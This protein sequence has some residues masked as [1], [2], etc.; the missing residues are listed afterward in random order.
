MRTKMLLLL[1]AV[2][3]GAF[4]ENLSLVVKNSQTPQLNLKNKT[5]LTAPA[6]GLW[7][8]ATKWENQWPSGWKHAS[9]TKEEQVGDWQVLTGELALKKGRFLIRDAY[10][11]EGNRVK[12]IRRFRWKGKQP[13]D[14][15]TLS[16]RWQFK[17]ELPQVFI[18][19]IIYYGNPSGEKNGAHKLPVY[20][21][22]NG[23]KAIFEEHRFPLP[24]A[25]F[26]WK[27]GNK[28]MGAALHTKPSPVYGGKHFDQWWSL[29][30]ESFEDYSELVMLSG[31]ITYNGKPSV[32]KALQHRAMK[33][34][35]TWMKFEPGD[36]VEKTFYL[37]AYDVKEQGSGFQ[38]PMYTSIDIFKPFYTEDFPTFQEIITDKYRFTKSRYMETDDYAGFNMYPS[39]IT[40]QVVMGWAGQSEAPTYAL[41]VLKDKIGDDKVRGMVQKSLDHISTST[42]T[43]KGFCVR[44]NTKN[45]KWSNTD[46]VSEGQAMNSIALAIQAGRKDKKM[47]T[48]KWEVFLKKACDLHLKRINDSNWKPRNTAEAFY[49]SPFLIASDLFRNKEYKKLALKIADYYAKR[50]ISMEEPY[51]GG[52]LDATCEDKEGAWGAFQG[53]MT[54]YEYTK[55]KK[56]LKWAKHA[57]DVVL[58]Y[59]VV[60]DIP[61]PAGRLADHGLKTRG[62]TGV[63]PQNQHLDVYGVLVTPMVYKLGM[64]TNNEALKRLAIVMYR[65]CGQMIDPYGS[66]GEQIQETNFAQHGNMSNVYKLRG[67]YSESW[68]VYWI[69]A[70]FLHAA[71]QFVE[72]GVEIE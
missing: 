12:C 4:A 10:R 52:T 61:L 48:E 37:E 34:G 31:P 65:S 14:S 20:H 3:S 9:P 58:S 56:Y 8:I 15:V 40:P 24:F 53:F 69:T 60:W 50:H 44:Y 2:A 66:Q 67:G 45:K 46:P 70:H 51:W 42:L 11:H 16:V 27:D 59:T 63:S 26:E 28:Y 55:E 7:S 17:A 57:G 38:T 33:Y 43:D 68:S 47:N 41:Q 18:P 36:I 54:A 19:G 23:E 62:W 32:A 30:V 39:H 35:E 49:I 71:A 21:G 5:V 72:M 13:I 25:S 29:G 64:Y 1:L 22:K 6:E